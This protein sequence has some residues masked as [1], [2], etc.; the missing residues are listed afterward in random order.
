MG[1]MLKIPIGDG[2]GFGTYAA[3]IGEFF[4]ER[5]VSK[6]HVYPLFD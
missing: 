5:H 6:N 2:L 4:L 3:D 1:F